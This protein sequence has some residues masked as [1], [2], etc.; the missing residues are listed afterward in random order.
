[1]LSWH[2]ACRCTAALLL[3]AVLRRLGIGAFGAFDKMLVPEQRALKNSIEHMATE[4]MSS[5]HMS[6]EHMSTEQMS[7]THVK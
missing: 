4:H 6:N 2:K 7:K 1:M 3:K 5:N